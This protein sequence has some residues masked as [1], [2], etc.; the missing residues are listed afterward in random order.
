MC[1]IGMMAL[2][3]CAL[4]GIAVAQTPAQRLASWSQAIMRQRIDRAEAER[5]AGVVKLEAM[6]TQMERQADVLHNA[7]INPTND[8]QR[9]E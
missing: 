3:L 8:G 2:F 6:I 1:R 7:A 4:G 5:D 9:S